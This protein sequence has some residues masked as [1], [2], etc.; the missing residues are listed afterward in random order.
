MNRSASQG[1]GYLTQAEFT[2]DD[3]QK[4]QGHLLTLLFNIEEK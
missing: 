3:G 2:R 4:K 1:G